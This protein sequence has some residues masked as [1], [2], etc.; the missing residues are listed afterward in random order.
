[1]GTTEGEGDGEGDGAGDALDAE[2]DEAVFA[3]ALSTPA[4]PARHTAG[5]SIDALKPHI[6]SNFGT[7]H[8]DSSYDASHLPAAVGGGVSELSGA[9]H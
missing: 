8:R 3:W 1:M 2:M 6:G 5:A 9:S 7:P 4:L